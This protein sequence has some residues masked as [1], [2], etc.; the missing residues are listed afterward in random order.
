MK[1]IL[2]IY[3]LL[4]VSP[5]FAKTNTVNLKE[6]G[7]SVADLTPKD[8]KLLASAQGD[9]N[10]DGLDDLVFIIQ[11]TAPENIEKHTGLGSNTIDL[12]PRIMAIYFQNITSK[13]YSK[14]KQLD[15]FIVLRDSP[16]MDEPLD[17]IS[18]T[19]KGVLNI[20]FRFWYSAGSWSFSIHNY[21]FRY[22]QNHFNLIAYDL[23][24][25]HRGSG[26]ETYYGINFLTKKMQVTVGNIGSNK[27][28]SNEWKIFKLEELK[29]FESLKSLFKWE[30]MG[31][32][33]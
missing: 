15:D 21:A 24:D 26:E 4:F 1:S 31:L 16:T 33:L 10:K 9:L 2:I 22:E 8:W 3:I 7:A 12:N 28:D 6:I 17:G 19:D 30:F 29:N 20:T 18:I 13:T 11:N 25:I 14:Q 23:N 5:L 27:I 32:L